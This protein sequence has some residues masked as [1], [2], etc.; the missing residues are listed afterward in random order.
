MARLRSLHTWLLPLLCL[1]SD[2]VAAPSR[3]AV[4]G[5]GAGGS[6]AAFWISKG[7][8]RFGVDIE[9]DVY[10]RES[11]VGGRSTVVYPHGD[12]S[13][14]AIELGASIFADVNK[15]LQ[16]AT[17]EFGLTRLP[18]DSDSELGI[19]DG[20]NILLSLNG[21]ASDG[22]AFVARYGTNG[23]QV[24]N[25]I[26]YLGV[27]SVNQTYQKFLTLYSPKFPAWNSVDKLATDLGW[28][29]LITQVASRFM[30]AAGINDIFINEMV[31][32]STRINYGQDVDRLHALGALCSSLKPIST[33]T[34]GLLVSQVYNLVRKSANTDQW[35]IL[36]GRGTT[37]YD[38]VILAAPYHS[39]RI[40]FPP[41]IVSQQP[42]RHYVHLHVTL[43]ATTSES[44]NPSYFASNLSYIPRTMLTTNKNAKHGG[45]APEFNSISYYSLVRDGEWVVKIFSKEYISNEFLN[46]IFSS[47]EAVKWVQR[48]E[49]DAYPEYPPTTIFPSIKLDTGL[50]YVNA[51]EPFISTMET[52]TISS[53]N[54]VD[55]M[56]KEQFNSSICGSESTGPPPSTGFVFGW[57]C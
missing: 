5:A 20:E 40:L 54:V 19:W 25:T 34:M 18:P 27:P 46:K 38:A 10:E 12:K 9:V 32:G 16:R 36:S 24:L 30:Q 23:P 55:L 56:L 21:S 41:N 47:P 11:Y 29:G 13:L 15:N 37:E 7:K 52:E 17:D 26:A 2:T 43:I 53:R 28:E 22:A 14:P 50:Y 3:V 39:T 51:F 48:K 49:W 8:E 44:F 57:D 4:I 45:K 33:L 35:T 1:V 31:E 42:Q 6:S